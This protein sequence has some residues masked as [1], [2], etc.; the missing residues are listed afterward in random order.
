MK[1][2]HLW[3]SGIEE[4]GGIQHYS[5]CCVR[6]L[7]ELYP[8]AELRVFSKND[9]RD[10]PAGG[11]HAFGSRSGMARTL[12]FAAS[13]VMW[14]LKEKPDFV[15]STHPHFAKAMSPLRWAGISCLTAAHGIEVWGQLGGSFGSA[16]RSMTG[17]LPV[18][19]FTRDVIQRE[20][21]VPLSRMP[22]VPN[23]FREAN[24]S[25]GPKAAY[26]L[27]R[28][29]L[30]AAQ[31]VLFTVGRLS[32][33]ERYKGQDQVLQALPKLV[34]TLPTLRYVIGGRG[35]D[36]ARLRQ[37]VAELG[38]EQHVIFTGFIP[39]AELADYYRLADLYVMPS[40]GEGFGIVYLESLACGRPCLVGSEDA[41]PEAVD[42]GRLGFVV[43]PRDPE[44]IAAAILKFFRREHEQP[45]LHEP[46]T[47]HREVVKLYGHEAFKMYLQ[48]ALNE[49]LPN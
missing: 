17:I 24:F 26:L 2:I 45:W 42:H 46:E 16:L 37:M 34:Q 20:G 38:L 44:K 23:T 4:T 25:P 8:Q 6:A 48:R 21:Q 28:H 36:E 7:R 15:L 13:G 32:A 41:S 22:V 31:P 19:A 47:L 33:T 43:P 49:L 12:A 10:D 30:K 5:D 9:M 27:E 29:G 1:R 40:T 11:F 35:D 3:V 18:S 14:A 39:E